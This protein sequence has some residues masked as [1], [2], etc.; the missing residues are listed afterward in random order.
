MERAQDINDALTY[1][2]S[3]EYYSPYQEKINTIYNY[4]EELEN[5]NDFFKGSPCDK[6][7]NN[8]K[9]GGSGICHCILGTPQITC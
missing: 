5:K 8:I 3:Y 1:L 9:N 7:S 6:C 2:Y 4:I